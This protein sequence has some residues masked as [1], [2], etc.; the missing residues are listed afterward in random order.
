[1]PQTAAA[2]ASGPG[3][4]GCPQKGRLQRSRHT[5]GIGTAPAATVNSSGIKHILFAGYEERGEGR[6]ER[7]HFERDRS[8]FPHTP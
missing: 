3:G 7:V 6:R 8:L 5:F 1:M 2:A 4:S